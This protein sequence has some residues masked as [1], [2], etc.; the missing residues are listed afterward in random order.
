MRTLAIGD[1]HGC[2]QS[3]KRLEK[4]A[5]FSP[6]DLIVT[7]GDHVDRGPDS[8]KVINWLIE[9]DEQQLVALR[10]NHE[11]M[12][13]AARDSF[14]HQREWFACGGKAVLRSYGVDHPDDIPDKH[15]RFLTKNLCSHYVHGNHFFVHANAYPDLELNEQPDYM[16]YWE[17]KAERAP[18]QS[19]RIMI[20][21]HTPQRSG[22]PLDMGHAICID[23]GACK[24][25]WLTCMDVNSRYCW[26]ANEDGDVRGFLLDH[27]PDE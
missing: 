23:T 19:G 14:D 13:L 15:W 12:M 10:G 5:K 24:G 26:Q 21:G 7:L 22:I 17:S 18:H 8:R 4:F 1:I 2:Y 20:C 25:G 3:L 27:G 11:L 9:R 6:D 16:L